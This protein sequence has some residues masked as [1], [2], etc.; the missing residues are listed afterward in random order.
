M[1]VDVHASGYCIA[2]AAIVDPRQNRKDIR[3]YAAW[4][5][6]AHEQLGHL[7]VD[8]GYNRLFHEATRSFPSRLYA[9]ATPVTITD[10]DTAVA[11]LKKKGVAAEEVKYIIITH[12][13]ADHICALRDF[14][15][16][17]FICSRS[18]LDDVSRLNGWRAV[19][20]GVL[21][22][23]LPDDFYAR[24]LAIEDVSPIAIQLAGGLTARSLF[25]DPM[26]QLVS[27]PGHA[28]GMLGV[29]LRQTDETIFYAADAQWD[30]EVFEA[31]VWPSK[32]VKLFFGSWDDFLTT[33]TKLRAYMAAE[34]ATRL[35]FTHCKQTLNYI[36]QCSK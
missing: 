31:G 5:H 20:K 27:M 22:P 15:N 12:F 30:K 9:W 6:I 23:L 1:T 21:K 4:L 2:D 26:I 36:S 28:T 3:F 17:Q 8:T 29:L 14:P 18:A 32:L 11:I 34:P 24:V 25:G 16:A 10:E 13:H 19:S 7:L 35:M 33:T